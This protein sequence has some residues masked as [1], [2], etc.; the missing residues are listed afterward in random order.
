M[1]EKSKSSNPLLIRGLD[2]FH[3]RKPHSQKREVQN[4]LLSLGAK[5]ASRVIL[6][7]HH[8]LGE[9]IKVKGIHVPEYMRTKLLNKEWKDF[10]SKA[11]GNGYSLSV[12]IHQPD[13]LEWLDSQID[14]VFMSP[15]FDSISKSDYMASPYWKHAYKTYPYRGKRIAL[16]GI[17]KDNVAIAAERGFDGIAVLGAIWK[18]KGKELES[19]KQIQK[20]CQKLD[21]TF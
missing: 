9:I 12:S 10:I 18:Q 19:F 1:K 11:K 6:H 21:H 16:G 4:M 3:L 17:D 14:Y 8:S 5:Y 15:V 20:V 7:S 2:R 13:Q